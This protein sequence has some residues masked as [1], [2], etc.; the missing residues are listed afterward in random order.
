MTY[1]ALGDSF[2]G[3]DGGVPPWPEVV[4]QRLGVSLRNLATMGATSSDVE[5]E[6]L[7]AALELE[8]ELVSVVCGA[9]DV[10]LSYRPDV[11]AY[12][13]RLDRMLGRLHAE[14]PAA[15][16][17]TATT[18][19]FARWLPLHERSLRRVWDGLEAVAAATRRVAEEHGVPCMPVAEHPLSR[20]RACFGPDGIHASERGRDLTARYIAEALRPVVAR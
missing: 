17:F 8:P 10:L 3:G 15:R 12:A 4:A 11:D 2:S 14:L 5:R 20:D 9:N 13:E 1:V 16:V 18:P 6:Q 19:N 7:P